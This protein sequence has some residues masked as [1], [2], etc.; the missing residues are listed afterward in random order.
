MI[1][2]EIHDFTAPGTKPTGSAHTVAYHEWPARDGSRVLFCAHGLTRNAVDFA[3][4]APA[5]ADGWREAYIVQ[6]GPMR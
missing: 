6:E 5:F 4:L 3:V 1:T 2:P